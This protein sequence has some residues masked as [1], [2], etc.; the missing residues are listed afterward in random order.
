MKLITWN[1]NG[2]RACMGKGFLDFVRKEAPYIMCVQETKMQ[3]GQAD[4]PLEGYIQF[5]NSAEK[6]GYSGTVTF[7][8]KE[9]LSVQN[10]I[11]APGHDREGRT[12]TLE[13]DNFYIINVYTPNAQ[14]GLARIDYRMEWEDAFRTYVKK[15]DV[16][17]PVII[18]GDLNVAHQEIDLKN[19]KSNRGNAGFSDE[20]R[21]KFTELLEAG[22]T[23][24]FR[25]LYPDLEG[26]YTWWTYRFNARANNAGWRID[27]FLVSDRIKNKVNDVILRN[28]IYGSD[29]CPVVMHIDL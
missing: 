3:E 12:I 9:P 15:L 18:C 1:V 14:E 2:L 21:A 8:L 11:D 28:D 24:T 16:K 22:F 6:K 10:D 29:H 4:V 27:Y 23:D 7:T 26:A 19:P 5:W 13:Y 17:K 25:H 20:E